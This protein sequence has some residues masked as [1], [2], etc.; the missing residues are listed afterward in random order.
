MPL[1]LQP[2]KKRIE[3]DQEA[4]KELAKKLKCTRLF[5][6]VLYNRGFDT[7]EKCTAFLHPGK[8]SFGDPFLL[9]NMRAAVERIQKAIQQQ[10]KVTIYG[11][12]DVDGVC[13]VALV[14]K[15]LQ[16]LGLEA[17]CYIPDRHSEGYGLNID[18]VESIAGDGT[19]LLITVDCG[20]SAVTEIE[21]AK[22]LHMDVLVTDHHALQAVLP[23]C[24]I[25]NPLLQEDAYPCKHLCGAGVAFKLAQALLGLEQARELLDYA[26]IATV[27]DIVPLTE[28]N[29]AIVKMGLENIN[30]HPREGIRQL[31]LASGI[32]PGKLTST[33]I[34]FMLA[35]RLNAAGRMEHAYASL[36]L[37]LS[38]DEELPL[39]AARLSQANTKRQETEGQILEQAIKIAEQSCLVRDS[40]VLVIAGEDWEDGVIGICA[41]RM[42]ER[43]HRPCIIFSVKDGI[44]K[45]SG[46]SVPGINLFEMLSEYSHLFIKYG[47]HEMAAGLSMD[48]ALLPQLAQSL[49]GYVRE[50]CDPRLLLPVANYDAKALL[51]EMDALLCANIQLL[52]P[53]GY[54]NT[55]PVF[56]LDDVNITNPRT[57]GKD[58]SHLKFSIAGQNQRLDGIAFRYKNHTIDYFM[59]DCVTLIGA[60]EINEWKG[61]Y[62]VSFKVNHAKEQRNV[63]QILDKIQEEEEELTA[64]FLSQLSVSPA[65]QSENLPIILEDAEEFSAAVLETLE[66]DIS[67]TLLL[68]SHPGLAR[69]LA[70]IVAGASTRTDIGFFQPP[71]RVNGYNALVIAPSL[72]LLD[73][74]LYKHIIIGDA[75]FEGFLD[76][77]CASAPWA[78]VLA[79]HISPQEAFGQLNKGYLEFSRGKMA[80]AYKA[81]KDIHGSQPFASRRELVGFLSSVGRELNKPLVETA[82]SVFCELSFFTLDTAEGVSCKAN[83]EI[84]PASLESSSVYRLLQQYIK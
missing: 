45:G 59:A 79:L 2:L 31:M 67:G 66:E 22:E 49:D 21:K 48:P 70:A 58:N 50:N 6:E 32:E 7:P 11:D 68:V 77:V 8:S 78:E 41:S 81:I 73:L 10:E 38:Q 29:R 60:P 53:T 26:A 72:E 18:A 15:A 33:Q 4:V 40:K 17:Q 44:A 43:F 37:L 76:W 54:K 3:I 5:A 57:I 51:S 23:D 63:Q 20:I 9:K 46:R 80:Q 35:P 30:A 39:Q 64:A 42:A 52:Q 16:M 71:D 1:V 56:R 84:Q 75:F 24:L 82:L 47:G 12:Y 13:S 14:Y 19:H 62:S 27:A 83:E 36:E 34:A 55:M 25:I 74:R 69:Q 65:E 28:E 61:E